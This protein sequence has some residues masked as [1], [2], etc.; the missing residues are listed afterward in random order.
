MAERSWIAWRAF[1]FHQPQCGLQTGSKRRNGQPVYKGKDNKKNM[2]LSLRQPHFYA[3][4]L[5]LFVA[6]LH[7]FAHGN[8][9][10]NSGQ[11]IG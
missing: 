2:A 1:Y 11:T 7:T 3:T 6:K 4:A 10:N 8:T 9:E 5:F